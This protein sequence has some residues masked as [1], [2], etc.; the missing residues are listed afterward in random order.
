M[1]QSWEYGGGAIPGEAITSTLN[2]HSW[3]SSHINEEMTFEQYHLGYR[4]SQQVEEGG[5]W[6]KHSS[7][8]LHDQQMEGQDQ[9][10]GDI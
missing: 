4:N 5:K 3:R 2:V 10:K 7:S 9:W 6:D 8:N 1:G